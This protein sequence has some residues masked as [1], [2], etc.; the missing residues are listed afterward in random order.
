M[1]TLLPTA[2][3]C[4]PPATPTWPAMKLWLPSPASGQLPTVTIV[5]AAPPAPP[6]P[7]VPVVPP[8]AATAPERAMT[9][10]SLVVD[11]EIAT[12]DSTPDPAVPPPDP[13]PPPP[14]P[15]CTYRTSG[16]RNNG[17]VTRATPDDP[18]LPPPPR[19]ELAAP[20]K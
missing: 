15:T 11:G 4:A 5:D 13:T 6:A 1:S 14:A 18:P 3:V 17:I 12:C 20:V 10:A 8:T 19:A 16:K 9:F 7:L 2:P